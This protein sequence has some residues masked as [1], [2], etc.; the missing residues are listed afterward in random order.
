MA[1]GDVSE[2]TPAK[3][4]LYSRTGC[5][6]CEDAER[7]LDGLKLPYVRVEVGSDPDL[8][9]RYGWDVPVLARGDEVLLKGVFTRARVLAKLG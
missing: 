7:L 4:T 5:H 3:L 2:P 9:A 6:L 8:E 1:A